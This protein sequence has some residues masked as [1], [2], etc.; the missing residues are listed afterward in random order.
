MAVRVKVRLSKQIIVPIRFTRA[1]TGPPVADAPEVDDRGF[2]PWTRPA[3]W[4]ASDYRGAM[5]SLAAGDTVRIKVLREEIDS[6]APLFI[7]S[8]DR[9]IASVVEPAP[10]QPLAGDGIFRLKGESDQANRPVKIQVRLGAADGPV[11]GELEPHIFQMR[12][13]RV[14][15]HLVTINGVA[16]TRTANSMVSVFDDINVIWRPVGIRFDYDPALTRA[17]TVT[18]FAVP[19]QMTTNLSGGNWTEFSTLIN[20]HPD[21]NRI[22][23]Y[24]VR[25]ANEVFGLTFANTVARP[26]GYGIVIADNSTANSNA[27]ELCH[28]LDNPEH[29]HENAART[30]VRT[31]IWAR[32]RL[33]WTPSPYP[34]ATPAYRNDVGYGA[35]LRGAQITVKDLAGDPWDGE[36]ARARRRSLNPY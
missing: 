22:N 33:M 32:R 15:V 16:T 24:C 1:V 28:Y 13:L 27:H 17:E 7:T 5:V 6:S 30:N 8:S 14:R 35:Q 9:K 29:A 18:G 2:G 25:T 20:L 10:G 36:T 21:P 26:N 3:S 23:M 11:L 12:V 19:G 4:G 34:N 31:D